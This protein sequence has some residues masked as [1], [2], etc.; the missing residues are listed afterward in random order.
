MMIVNAAH[1]ILS[2]MSVTSASE[3]SK[4]RFTVEK[5][6]RIRDK[7]KK[8]GQQVDGS[9][10]LK[11]LALLALALGKRWRETAPQP[12]K[13]RGEKERRERAPQ[14]PLGPPRAEP[15]SWA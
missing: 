1:N 3:R 4:Q 9:A 12:P 2:R 13:I 11:A 6:D 14:S 8:E 10:L 15:P 5:N 7:V